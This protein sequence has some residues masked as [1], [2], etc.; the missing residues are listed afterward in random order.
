MAM[1]FTARAFC[2]NKAP[3]QA[4]QITARDTGAN[5]IHTFVSTQQDQKN[6]IKSI[7]IVEFIILQHKQIEQMFDQQIQQVLRQQIQ[8][9][10]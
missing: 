2:R 8:Q 6:Q 4:L 10:K 3:H 7:I 9:I 1:Y 5:Y